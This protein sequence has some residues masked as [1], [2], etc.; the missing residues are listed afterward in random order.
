MKKLLIVLFLLPFCV[1]AQNN[2]FQERAA[3]IDTYIKAL[4]SD[5]NI[6]GLA[7][8]IV[9]KDQVIY[10]KGYGFRDLE[11]KIQATETTLFPIA[12]NTKLFTATLATQFAAEGKLSLDV[13]VKQYLPE[14]NFYNPELNFK[15][16][17]RDL[18]SHRT[19]LPSYDGIWLNAAF[20]RKE[21]LSKISFMK[22][23]LGFREGYIYNNNMYT[24]AGLAIEAVSGKSWEE[25]V[26]E[27]IFKP[28]EMNSSGFTGVG[29]RP[30]NHSLSY[31][32]AEGT[33][34]L[35]ARTFLA[36]SELLA[37]AGN[38]YS[39]MVDM[40]KWLIL[41]VNGGKYKGKQVIAASAIEETKVP[42]AI[43]DKRGRYDEL[44]NSIYAMGR[45]LQSYK[46]TKMISHTG[47]IDGFYSNLSYLPK[48]S[49]ALF[50]VHNSV[51]AGSLRS[52]MN[53]PIIDILQNREIT[54][55]SARYRKDY[56]EARERNKKIVDGINASQVKNTY[57]SHLALAYTG[58][59]SHP[60]YGEILIGLKNNNLQLQYRSLSATLHHWHYDQFIT[61]DDGRGFPDMRISFL[62]NDKGEIDRISTRPFGDPLTEFVRVK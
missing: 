37:P 3:K 41:Q 30:E 8:V 43:S 15:I 27:R 24:L 47:S 21:L 33:G 18:L 29:A 49:I 1:S 12:S 60:V 55:W 50:I 5:W 11:N 58:R 13:P 10:T 39:S 16:S 17:I 34:K 26:H 54:D 23:S 14:V 51:S 38:I 7:L 57:P 25:N 4:L 61:M 44:S 35:T 22:P 40:S 2:G 62:T 32:E 45:S 31:F 42:N 36:Q 46:G 52:V 59:F 56:L 19:G 6:P 9:H 53:L 28:L 48:D 20:K